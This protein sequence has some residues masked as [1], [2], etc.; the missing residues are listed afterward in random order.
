PRPYYDA[1]A[2]AAGD[3]P[4]LASPCPSTSPPGIPVEVLPDLPVRGMKDSSGEPERLLAELEV[5]HQPLYVGAAMILLMA[6]SLRR[7]RAARARGAPP[8]PVRRGGDDPPHGRPPRRPR[9][10]PGRRQR[11]P[12]ARHR[13]LRRRPRRPAGPPPRPPQGQTRLPL[14]PH[15]GHRRPVRHLPRYPPRLTSVPSPAGHITDRLYKPGR[16]SA[17]QVLAE[18][19]RRHILDLLREGERWGNELVAGLG[20]SQPGVSKHVRVLRDA[21]LVEVRVDAQRRLYALQP[22]ALT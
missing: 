8:A 7:P 6:G 3:L 10:H 11:R 18:P 5:F 21:G 20:L 9:R 19:N 4:S 14:P 15:A 12:R 2:E 17:F 22:Q 13:R 16:M 1:V